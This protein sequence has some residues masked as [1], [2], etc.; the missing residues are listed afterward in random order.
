MHPNVC[1]GRKEKPLDWYEQVTHHV[2]CDGDTNKKHGKSQA[3]ILERIVDT[4]QQQ[5][6]WPQVFKP[7][8]QN[9]VSH[10]D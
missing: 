10:Y 3:L 8:F 6:K 5:P 7:K 1:A 2:R 9:E 4:S